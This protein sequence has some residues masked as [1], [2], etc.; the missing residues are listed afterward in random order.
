MSPP[1]LANDR[2][3]IL[4]GGDV[5]LRLKTPYSGSCDPS[6]FYTDGQFAK[7]GIEKLVAWIPK[8]RMHLVRYDGVFTP[9]SGLRKKVVAK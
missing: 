2:L 1:P 8:P 7:I 9:N 6:P 3:E 5:L 4:P